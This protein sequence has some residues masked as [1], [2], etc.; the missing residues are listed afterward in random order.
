M[1][2]QKAR[3]SSS[4]LATKTWSGVLSG[5]SRRQFIFTRMAVMSSSTPDGAAK[6]D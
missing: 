2:M 6:A 3:L 5:P 1:S 4:I